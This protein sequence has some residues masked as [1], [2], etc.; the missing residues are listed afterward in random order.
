MIPT[1]QFEVI[2]FKMNKRINFEV[3]LRTSVQGKLQNG[4]KGIIKISPAQDL[5]G[6]FPN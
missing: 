3:I 6:R 2:F 4:R 1:V 5:L